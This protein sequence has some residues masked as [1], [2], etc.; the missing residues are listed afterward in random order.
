MCSD[1]ANSASDWGMPELQRC[2]G[3]ERPLKQE[4][5]GEDTY[6]ADIILKDMLRRVK[7][8][9]H[10]LDINRLSQFRVD[11]HPSIYGN[12]RHVGMDCTHWCLPGVPDVWNHLLYATLFTL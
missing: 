9:I 3:E 10:L 2:G 6:R 1:Y 7:K 4:M 12:P 5:E 11:G 8:P